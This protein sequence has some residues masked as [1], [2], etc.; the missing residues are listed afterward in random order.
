MG[1]RVDLL[2]CGSG[3]LTGSQKTQY[4]VS[5]VD[6]EGPL[7]DRVNYK[8]FHKNLSGEGNCSVAGRPGL[9]AGQPGTLVMYPECGFL[10]SVVGESPVCPVDILGD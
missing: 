5:L 2:H 7:V 3:Q 4:V 1:P 6:L 10:L 8:H 9:L